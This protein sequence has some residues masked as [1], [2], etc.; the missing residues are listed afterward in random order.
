MP[1]TRLTTT[2]YSV[3]GLLGLGDW[4]AY[5][6]AGLMARSVGLVL[7]RA[8]S[9]IYEE[10]KRLA[11]RKLVRAREEARGKRTVSVYS[12]TPTGRAA[13]RAWL[14]EPSTFP[15]LDAEAI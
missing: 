7:S 12:I 10:P 2:S 6:L 3:L 5:E 15:S 8:P 11:A 13:L 9:V 1:E 4:T 14:D